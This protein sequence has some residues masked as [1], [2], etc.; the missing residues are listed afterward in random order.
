[1][2]IQCLKP[3]RVLE[4]LMS[5]EAFSVTVGA[6]FPFHFIVQSKIRKMKKRDSTETSKTEIPSNLFYF[7]GVPTGLTKFDDAPI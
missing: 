7:V 6:I 4:S 2:L 1:M 5:L 3:F